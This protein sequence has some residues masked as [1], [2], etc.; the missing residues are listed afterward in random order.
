M[1]DTSELLPQPV[2]FASL[3]T[4]IASGAVI[5]RDETGRFVIEKPIYRDNWLLPGGG[6]DPG[7]DPRQCAQREVAEELG[8]EI[9]VGALLDIAWR[10]ARAV[11]SAPMGA[12]FIFDGGVIPRAELEERI[13][14]QPEEI[15]QWRLIGPEEAHL[16]SPWGSARALRA[17]AVAEGRAPADLDARP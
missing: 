1:A 10:P 2:Y 12:H 17:L 3:P 15:S 8:L 11:D 7:E 5:L 4:V 6:V 9:T 16:L 14:L 13:V